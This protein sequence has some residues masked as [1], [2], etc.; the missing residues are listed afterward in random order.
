M[1]ANWFELVSEAVTRFEDN[2]SRYHEAAKA[3]ADRI[4]SIADG[5]RI[6]CTISHRAKDI[7][8]FHKKI[9]VK[10]YASPWTDVTDKC[11]VRVVVHSPKDVD[12]LSLAIQAELKDD[13][14]GV[15]DKRQVLDPDRLGYSGVHIQAVAVPPTDD[16][17]RIECELQLRTAAQDAWS[18]V[19]HHVLYKPLLDLPPSEQHRAYR[20]VAL[21][22]MFDEEVQRILDYLESAPGTDLSDLIDVAESY[23]LPLANSPS[24]RALSVLVLGAIAGTFTANERAN[25]S[26]ILAFFVSSDEAT[27]KQLYRDYGPH[28]AVNYVPDYIMFGQA[29]SLIL[30]ERL[31]VA[32]HKL[33][34]AWTDAGLPHSYLE[35]LAAAAGQP[36]PD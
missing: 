30:L 19:S 18:I 25:Y 29:E 35:A 1:D 32:P 7:R 6:M 8:S 11:G 15:E 23:F 27:L 16:Y 26:E 12:R 17:E 24:N 22:E 36:L 21:V 3:M 14:L 9:I 20:L 5:A 31:S 34:G 10:E 33:L 4:Q 2:H 28:S 13:Y